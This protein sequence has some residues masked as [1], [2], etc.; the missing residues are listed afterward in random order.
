[1]VAGALPIIGFEAQA[2]KLLYFKYLSSDLVDRH[3][4]LRLSA[5]RLTTNFQIH[6]NLE[7]LALALKYCKDA[8]R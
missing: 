4:R 2:A 6:E 8:L 5:G 3:A 1:M 7:F